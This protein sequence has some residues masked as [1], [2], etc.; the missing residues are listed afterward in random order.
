LDG[1]YIDVKEIVGCEVK[2]EV[3]VSR[4]VESLAKVVETLFDEVGVDNVL[5]LLRGFLIVLH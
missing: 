3:S 2:A 5:S 1:S 4:I